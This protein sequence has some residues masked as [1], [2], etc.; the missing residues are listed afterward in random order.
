M[1]TS[2]SRT[3]FSLSETQ[4]IVLSIR[5]ISIYMGTTGAHPRPLRCRS[6]VHVAEAL[7]A[8]RCASLGAVCINA[9]PLPCALLFPVEFEPFYMDVSL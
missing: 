3:A 4:I 1:R 7:Q 9:C 5:N 6:C 2:T 8:A